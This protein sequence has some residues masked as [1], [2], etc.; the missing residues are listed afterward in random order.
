MHQQ[1]NEYDMLM[2]VAARLRSL[3]VDHKRMFRTIVRIGQYRTS[4]RRVKSRI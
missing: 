1:L 4:L 3:N 2:R